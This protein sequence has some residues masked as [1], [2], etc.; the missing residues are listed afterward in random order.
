MLCFFVG[1]DLLCRVYVDKKCVCFGFLD[2]G[3]E[4]Y[5][6]TMCI[7]VLSLLVV[8]VD[9]LVVQDLGC[10]PDVDNA[11]IKSRCNQLSSLTTICHV[12]NSSFFLFEYFFIFSTIY[13]SGRKSQPRGIMVIL[14]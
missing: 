14:L 7:W 4:E 9:T 1:F 8:Q 11:T 10:L 2:E 5:M 6:L 3:V 13:R 12:P